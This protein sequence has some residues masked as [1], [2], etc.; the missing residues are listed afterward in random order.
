[1]AVF[2]L[3][4]FLIFEK[5]IPQYGQEFQNPERV[6][7]GCKHRG[8]CG[9]IKATQNKRT[10]RHATADKGIF[11]YAKNKILRAIRNFSKIVESF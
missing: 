11:L 1:M 10:F 4:R 5:K 7:D 8:I 3:R 9:M 6:L 2:F